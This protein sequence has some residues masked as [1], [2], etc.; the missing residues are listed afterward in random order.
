MALVVILMGNI[1]TFQKKKG[2]VYI[3][4]IPTDTN[5]RKDP[6]PL[7]LEEEYENFIL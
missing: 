7:I 6:D 3:A 1:Y 5:K 2:V 4:A